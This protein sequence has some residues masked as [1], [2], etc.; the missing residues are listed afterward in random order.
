[1]AISCILD[2]DRS[3]FR[4]SPK[5]QTEEISQ[6]LRN[7]EVITKSIIKS[8]VIFLQKVNRYDQK[9]A[10]SSIFYQRF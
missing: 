5:C 3:I 9:L 8:K 7:T 4:F 10:V 1:M 6:K 2:L